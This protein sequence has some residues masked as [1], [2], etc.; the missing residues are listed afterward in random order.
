[1]AWTLKF[2]D[3]RINPWPRPTTTKIITQAKGA[4][5]NVQK[6]E[7]ASVCNGRHPTE[8]N[9]LSVTT[10]FWHEPSDYEAYRKYGTVER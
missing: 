5:N 10:G 8:P 4:G 2:R 3:M 1:M 9:G 7:K 6:D